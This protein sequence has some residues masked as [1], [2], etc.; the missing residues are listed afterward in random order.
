ME[1]N[2]LNS[3]F[4][5]DPIANF[6]EKYKTTS[7]QIITET[8]NNWLKNTKDVLDTILLQH[9]NQIKQL[10]NE[11]NTRFENDKIK[12]KKIQ[13]VFI[14]I[15]CF[16]IIGLFFLGFFI[17]N[18]NTIK[19]FEEFKS[20][21]DKE[22]KNQKDDLFNIVYANLR[23]L[24]TSDLL[25]QIL[26]KYG[27]ETSYEVDLDNLFNKFKPER[28]LAV[29][30]A[31]MIYFR[32]TPIYDLNIK[33]LNTRNVITSGSI[34]VTEKRGD[35][36][37]QK[38]IT[39]THCEP[40]PFI[41]GFNE[42][43]LLSNYLQPQFSFLS[44]ARLEEL[45]TNQRN[46]LISLEP[47]NNQQKTGLFGK[48]KQKIS[49]KFNDITH[50]DEKY[51]GI[52]LENDNFN[53]EIH[54]KYQGSDTDV[55]QFFSIKVQED[56]LKWNDNYCNLNDQSYGFNNYEFFN[57]KGFSLPFNSY[58]ESILSTCDYD[59]ADKV[60][61]MQMDALTNSLIKIMSSYL[62]DWFKAVQLPLLVTGINREWYQNDGVY[63]LAFGENKKEINTYTSSNYLINKWKNML[64]FHSDRP[65][66]DTWIKISKKEEINDNLTYYE[67]DL[68][69][70]SSQWLTDYV[71][72]EGYKVPVKYESFYKINEAKKAYRFLINNWQKDS[73]IQFIINNSINN[74]TINAYSIDIRNI[75]QDTLIEISDPLLVSKVQ[76]HQLLLSKLVNFIKKNKDFN[77]YCTLVLSNKYDGLILI[78]DIDWFDK[79]D[80]NNEII[81]LV[82]ELNA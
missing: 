53:K 58:Y 55:M 49:N 81:N 48:L 1:V 11:I 21:K 30:N 2:L 59:T 36:I 43:C 69:S 71:W 56:F 79:T 68:N 78:N 70:F 25:S 18:K 24:R 76:Q 57:E 72:K 5:V 44:K 9:Q 12:S 67:L 4:A 31:N 33:E 6:Y 66:R 65:Q 47:N 14:L 54:F 8:T 40:T 74:K 62:D 26:L 19:T 51:N 46:N 28:L 50:K 17:K 37:I 16:L 34:T 42:I 27:L 15:F 52:K 10:E 77:K 61:T 82:N 23:S 29:D 45:K 20:E 35:D 13:N 73:N 63:K 32:N 39:A 38:T 22:I 80:L 41:D 64:S 7:N 3:N 60:A 75:L